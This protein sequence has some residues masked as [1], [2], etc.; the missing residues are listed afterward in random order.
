MIGATLVVAA[1]ALIAVMNRTNA[2]AA[3]ASEV[4]LHCRDGS[5]L[6]EKCDFIQRSMTTTDGNSFRVSE[7]QNNCD[8][9]EPDEFGLAVSVRSS[10]ETKVETNNFFRLSGT[11]SFPGVFDATGTAV[12]ERFQTTGFRDETATT[13]TINAEV[14]PGHRGAIYF[15]PKVVEAAGFLE[16]TYKEATDGTKVFFFPERNADTVLV[17]FPLANDGGD[18][19]GFYWIREVECANDG[20]GVSRL[21]IPNFNTAG[22]G[23]LAGFGVTDTP[24]TVG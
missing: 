2:N 1:A 16:G 3:T 6:L 23:E 18:P 21:Q 17:R 13:V 19:E 14:K 24:V 22:F 15:R 11:V 5:P 20:P 12:S 8:G 10:V 9:T 7:P 4:A